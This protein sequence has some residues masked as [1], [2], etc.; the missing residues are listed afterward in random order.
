LDVA[1]ATLNAIK[2]RPMAI[3]LLSILQNDKRTFSFLSQAVGLMADVDL[4][5]EHLRWLGSTRFMY[6]YLRGSKCCLPALTP[7]PNDGNFS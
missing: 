6:G 7:S 1:A 5:T 2:G 4:G 3:D